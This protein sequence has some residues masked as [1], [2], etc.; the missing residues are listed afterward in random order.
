M[1]QA[2]STGGTG[3]RHHVVGIESHFIVDIAQGDGA[4]EAVETADGIETKGFL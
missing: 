4:V 1:R 3:G 2:R